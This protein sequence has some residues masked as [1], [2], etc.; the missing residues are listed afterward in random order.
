MADTATA[1]L[2]AHDRHDLIL[3]IG[4]EIADEDHELLRLL[5]K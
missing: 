3:A 5:A 1:V 2:R 4:R